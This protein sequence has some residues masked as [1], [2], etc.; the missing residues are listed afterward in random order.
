MNYPS[1]PSIKATLGAVLALTAVLLAA[2]ARAD[3][4][5]YQDN[6]NGND[7][8]SRYA[9]NSTNTDAG[10]SSNYPVGG[11]NMALA[12]TVGLLNQFQTTSADNGKFTNTTYTVAFDQFVKSSKDGQAGSGQQL[13]VTLLNNGY[14]STSSQYNGYRFFIYTNSMSTYYAGLYRVNT[15]GT[16]TTFVDWYLNGTYTDSKVINNWSNFTFGVNVTANS[17][18]LSLNWSGVKANGS[19]PYGYTVFTYSDTSASRYTSGSGL[20]FDLTGAGQ[21]A[22]TDN[23]YY[24]DNIVVTAVPEPACLSLLALGGLTLLRRRR[25]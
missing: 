1:T 21:Y 2:Q 8:S 6:C 13:A 9:F 15:N 14:N 4:T 24:I 22:N 20:G 3:V 10:Y 19:T 17:T 7:F 16:T 11:G 23:G 25:N 12:E 18:D 5:V